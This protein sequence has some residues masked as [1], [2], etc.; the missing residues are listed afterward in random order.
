M[1]LQYL[2]SPSPIGFFLK[3]VFKFCD[4]YAVFA[5]VFFSKKTYRTRN[6]EHLQMLL[7][8]IVDDFKYLNIIAQ[9]LIIIT[10]QDVTY[11]PRHFVSYA[12]VVFSKTSVC[13]VALFII[14]GMSLQYVQ[15]PSP[16]CFL[17]K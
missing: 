11:L 12:V 4:I 3:K 8:Q 1:P 17:I 9:H 7:C 16:I 10:S 2:P 13:I 5:H 6:M 14:S 15:T